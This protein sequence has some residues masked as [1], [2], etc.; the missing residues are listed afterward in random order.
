MILIGITGGVG[1]GKSEVIRY[2]E[3]TY[4]AKVLLADDV[5]NALKKPGMPCYQP[6][7]AC[8]GE[9]ILDS[10]GCINN[11]KMAQAIFGNQ[12]KLAEI[13]RIIHPA[14]RMQIESEIEKEKKAGRYDFFFLEA[15][16]LLE[17][18]YDEILDELWY[19]YAHE[20]V[21]RKRL[22]DGRGYSDEKITSIISKQ[23]A[24]E[25]FR[26]ACEV[27]IDNSGSFEETKK[28]ID[29]KMGVYLCRKQK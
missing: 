12:S 3:K 24:E 23:I 18:H 17:E 5:A 16:L 20:N 1:C 29:E 8:L 25:T 4:S 19:I 14:V 21:R 2:L 11:G 7:I 9:Q 22:K 10:D 15:A 6:V 26:E 13:N 27:I 28:Q